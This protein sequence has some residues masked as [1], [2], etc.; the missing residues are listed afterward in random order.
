MYFRLGT[1]R[2]HKKK[3]GVLQRRGGDERRFWGMPACA[4]ARGSCGRRN[5]FGEE[6]SLTCKKVE[7]SKKAIVLLGKKKI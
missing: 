6:G 3:G 7:N 1:G 2:I 5:V 4:H